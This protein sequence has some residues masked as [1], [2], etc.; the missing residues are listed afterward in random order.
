MPRTG[1]AVRRS[2]HTDD[3]ET[4]APQEHGQAPDVRGM[5][6]VTDCACQARRPGVA[7]G[8]ASV[9]RD[10]FWPGSRIS[11]C[12]TWAGRG[13]CDRTS[14]RRRRAAGAG[15]D[16]NGLISRRF[17]FGFGFG[18]GRRLGRAW[19]FAPARQ[20][21]ELARA[22]LGAVQ[23]IA[24]VARDGRCRSCRERRGARFDWGGLECP[25]CRERSECRVGGGRHV[26]R[27]V[28]YSARRGQGRVFGAGAQGRH[29]DG[30]PARARGAE[31]RLA[32]RGECSVGGA[33]SVAAGGD[34][35][36]VG[37]L[38]RARLVRAR[39]ERFG[40]PGELG[41]SERERGSSRGSGGD[42]ING[43]RFV[44]GRQAWR[45]GVRARGREFGAAGF[46]SFR[47]VAPGFGSSVRGIE[48]GSRI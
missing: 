48:G 15:R 34:S 21:S 45:A 22:R 1:P 38:V 36:R 19:R 20:G 8:C 16:R 46:G 29:A 40:R 24:G 10:R 3:G 42:T 2:R 32:A 6:P 41:G 35:R 28:G 39:R 18:L 27:S 44:N 47:V 7:H 13:L 9:C 17:G 5:W 23:A 37:P 31:A 4:A 11:T 26:G 25:R 30:G 14:G 33:G 43:R 12:S